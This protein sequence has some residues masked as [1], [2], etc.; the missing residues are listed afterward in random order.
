MMVQIYHKNY[1]YI[2]RNFLIFIKYFKK[3][4]KTDQKPNFISIYHFMKG[5]IFATSPSTVSKEQLT[6][7][8]AKAVLVVLR[9]PEAG[10]KTVTDLL[11]AIKH[12]PVADVFTLAT[13]GPLPLDLN[14]LL[15]QT[16]VTKVIAFGYSPS[17]LGLHV[18]EAHYHPYQIGELTYL[19]SESIAVLTSD[20]SKKIALWQALQKVFLTP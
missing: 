18:N 8:G 3:R 20:K 13:D 14:P 10:Q 7:S 15:A 9:T 6:G 11:K 1:L 19:F 4:T 2:L 5:K 12:D 17:E 16:G